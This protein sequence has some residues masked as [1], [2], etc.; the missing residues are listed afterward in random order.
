M[1]V[2]EME[3]LEDSLNDPLRKL[4]TKDHNKLKVFVNVLLH[5]EVECIINMCP[6]NNHIT[7][8]KVIK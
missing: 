5:S 1:Y 7:K 4:V 3:I 6:R 8:M 2:N